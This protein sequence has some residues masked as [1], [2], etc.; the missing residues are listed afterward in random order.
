MSKHTV[1]IIDDHLLFAQSLKGLINNFEDFEVTQHA[2]NGKIFI[3]N[4]K[5]NAKLPKI[6]LMDLNMPI[7]DGLETTKFLNE[8]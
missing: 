2:L 6:A 1:A 7:M 5:D 8:N 3:D 4:L